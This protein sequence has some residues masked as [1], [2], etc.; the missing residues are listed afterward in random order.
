MSLDLMKTLF[1]I[2]PSC[3]LI[4]IPAFSTSYEDTEASEWAKPRSQSAS[5]SLSVNHPL[6]FAPCKCSPHFTF[7]LPP[8]PAF[9]LRSQ[10]P[11]YPRHHIPLPGCP[12]GS[13]ERE[14]LIR[15]TCLS[16]RGTSA[17]TLTRWHVCCFGTLTQPRSIGDQRGLISP[18]P[19]RAWHH[20]LGLL[21][22]LSVL[23]VSVLPH[24]FP[25]VAVMLV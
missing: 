24:R 11:T 6:I 10:Y 9:V 5:L 19:R 3:F 20:G 22:Q 13:E 23:L 15:W 7:T 12:G 14:L 25:S 1:V 8:S 21:P 2:V 17:G 4:W 16:S 18:I